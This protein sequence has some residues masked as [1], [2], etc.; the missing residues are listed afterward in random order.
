M[1]VETIQNREKL[2]WKFT[3][4]DNMR[5]RRVLSLLV[6]SGWTK[7]ILLR[8][9]WKKS[10]PKSNNGELSNAKSLLSWCKLLL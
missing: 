2:T 10:I 4:G 7:M 5:Q 6:S 3:I 1:L 9:T 8:R